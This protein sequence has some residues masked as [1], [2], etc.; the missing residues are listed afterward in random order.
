MC[1]AVP[2]EVVEWLDRDPLFAKALIDF[3]GVRKPC[4]MACVTN[5]EVG[6]F[7]IVHAGI[8]IAKV[9]TEEA[10]RTRQDLGVVASE[11]GEA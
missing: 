11:G 2:G 5:A 9:N 1:L 4:H 8:A 10:L 3:G 6:D 7:V